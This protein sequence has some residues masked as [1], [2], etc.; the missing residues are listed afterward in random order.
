MDTNAFNE[1]FKLIQRRF[2]SN[3]SDYVTLFEQLSDILR[4]NG[5]Q[6]G[7]TEHY[8]NQMHKLAG[9]AKTF[10]F[11]ELNELAADVE[12]QLVM[13]DGEGRNQDVPPTLQR[14]LDTFLFE[15]RKIAQTNSPRDVAA[16]ESQTKDTASILVK[17]FDYSIVVVDDDELIREL[18]KNG[19]SQEKC[20]ITQAE[21]GAKVLQYLEKTKRYSLLTKPDLI[22]LDVNMPDISGFEVLERLKSDPEF[23]AI[24]V[25]M[26]TRRDEDE[27]VMKAYSSGAVD[28]ITKP[29]KAPELATRIMSALKRDRKT[30]LIADDDELIGDL[31]RQRFFLMGFTVLMAR[32]GTEALARLH[33]DQPNL[34]ILDVDMPGMDGLTVLKHA[35]SSRTSSH[36]PIIM[37]TK[38]NEKDNVVI[39]LDSG[40]HDY[41]AKPFD[42]DELAA[43]T[44]A[45]LRR[46]DT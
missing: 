18:V 43:R 8:R 14:A 2:I 17:E 38:R 42:I 36:V 26:L 13:I 22:V 44:H 25:I 21:N 27:S 4:Q 12:R 20:R 28:Y 15:A 11:P 1:S 40:A 5:D 35:K 29:F 24:P 16:T 31:L 34:A 37:L 30:I 39:A 6:I 46:Q 33:A 9:S 32:N 7:D 3:L 19:L 41:I 10:G 23:Q 45:I